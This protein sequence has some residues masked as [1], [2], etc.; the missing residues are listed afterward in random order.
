MRFHGYNLMGRNIKVEEIR[1]HPKKGRV[2]VP[3]NLVSYV[4]GEVK[5]TRDGKANDMRRIRRLEQNNKGD[6]KNSNSKNTTP[7][8]SSAKKKNGNKKKSAKLSRNKLT[9]L[10]EQEMQR[11]LKRGYLTLEGTGY[12]RGR[13]TSAL[14]CAHREWCDEHRQPQIVL[15]KASGGRPLDCIVVDLSPL[16]M[17]PDLVNM[18]D[19]DFLLY[20]KTQIL[21]AAANADMALRSDYLEDNCESL[22]NPAY[23]GIEDEDD[24]DDDGYDDYAGYDE[25]CID[26]AGDE[27]EGD[28]LEELCSILDEA[29]ECIVLMSDDGEHIECDH[30]VTDDD[31]E[32]RGKAK[33][34]AAKKLQRLTMAPISELPSQSLGVFEGERTN[35]KAMAKELALLWGIP[36][37]YIQ[38]Q[39]EAS[40]SAPPSPPDDFDSSSPNGG[41]K[42]DDTHPYKRRNSKQK[43]ED[44]R[45]RRRR[46][47]R[48]LDFYSF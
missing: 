19:H 41:Y 26:S 32:T 44:H 18:P 45:R 15:C 48:E 17:H 29:T 30:L 20:R 28:S 40:S 34:K 9:D 42:E 22:W 13:K 4:I 14:A 43:K 3:E 47:A 7:R 16:R 8:N 6:H 27:Y 39:E 10:E 46:Q 25:N 24:D 33:R 2:R 37:S 38:A 31:D 11:A 35:A 36:D 23:E 1:D 5:K 12:R 21:T